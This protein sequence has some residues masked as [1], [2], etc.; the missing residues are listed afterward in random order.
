[1]CTEAFYLC[2]L[3]IFSIFC[4]EFQWQRRIQR[5]HQRSRL[6]TSSREIVT[7]SSESRLKISIRSARSSTSHCSFQRKQNMY[8]CVTSLIFP[9]LGD[10]GRKNLFQATHHMRQYCPAVKFLNPTRFCRN[11]P[12][13]TLLFLS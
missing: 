4:N 3:L 7:K 8:F 1:M 5:S 11:P 9:P 6:T 10:F 12:S 2:I 13:A